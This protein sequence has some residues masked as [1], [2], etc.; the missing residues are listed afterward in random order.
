MIRG[1][2]V[3]GG[4]SQS[5]RS[6]STPGGASATRSGRPRPA[7]WRRAISVGTSTEIGGQ[8]AGLLVAL[9]GG[10]QLAIEAG[11][12]IRA[13]GHV[14]DHGVAKPWPRLEHDH[15]A[16]AVA[17]VDD[18]VV[19]AVELPSERPL[20]R[21]DLGGRG[22]VVRGHPQDP[23]LALALDVRLIPGLH[24]QQIDRVGR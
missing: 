12:A 22:I 3:G 7:A 13:A 20:E 19:G 8:E 15:A 18:V 4:D 21:V 17:T 2:P 10:L 24:D 16:P 5:K 11:A 9:A 23:D 1:P 14:I 6:T